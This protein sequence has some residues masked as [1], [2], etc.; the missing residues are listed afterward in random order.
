MRP[1]RERGV[2]CVVHSR[3]WTK[4][5][6]WQPAVEGRQRRRVGLL[7]AHDTSNMCTRGRHDMHACAYYVDGRPG[8]LPVSTTCAQG[9]R[10]ELLRLASAAGHWD[11]PSA[12]VSTTGGGG[13]RCG[14][15]GWVGQVVR[16]NDQK[17][18]RRGWVCMLCDVRVSCVGGA[19]VSP[20]YLSCRR[21]AVRVPRDEE[22]HTV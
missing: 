20:C 8:A 7:H 19:R 12:C 4:Q 1:G 16:K 21:L 5:W 14:A 17:N 15:R 22:C 9:A 10:D 13:W 11:C 2:T 6:W 18:S 3:V